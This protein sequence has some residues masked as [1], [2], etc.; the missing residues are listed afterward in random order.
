VGSV[1]SLDDF[2]NRKLGKNV[3]H[4]S[5]DFDEEPRLEEESL[6]VVGEL[7]ML[8]DG[9]MGMISAVRP[10]YVMVM[11]VTEGHDYAPGISLK[12]PVERTG[13]ETVL[14]SHLE[15]GVGNDSLLTCLG[16]YT[17]P[18]EV[19]QIR[20]APFGKAVSPFPAGIDPVV[21]EKVRPILDAINQ[22]CYRGW[23]A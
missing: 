12:V 18:T 6:P 11:P 22:L 16:A 17:T 8:I 13:W 4:V 10:G 23:D 14:W 1:I 15:T 7:W 20:L 21:E 3:T 9:N 5:F 2:R 19:S